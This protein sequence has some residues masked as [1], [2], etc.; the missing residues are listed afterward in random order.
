MVP[1]GLFLA[2]ENTEIQR[3]I[4]CPLVDIGSRGNV[5]RVDLLMANAPIRRDQL[6]K[7][8]SDNET[9]IRFQTLFTDFDRVDTVYDSRLTALENAAIEQEFFS[10]TRWGD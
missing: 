5:R 8:I 9:I 2:L 6:R 3:N 1:A 4:G 7:F 10:M